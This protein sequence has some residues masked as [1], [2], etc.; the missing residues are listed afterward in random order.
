M[1]QMAMKKA[2]QANDDL[3]ATAEVT[4]LAILMRNEAVKKKDELLRE[5]AGEMK[6]AEAAVSTSHFYQRQA[7]YAWMT[8]II[9]IVMMLL[10][11]ILM[12]T[13]SEVI[14]LSHSAGDILPMNNMK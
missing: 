8:T 2:N 3:L 7:T 14:H 12:A 1:G 6:K 9:V 5:K 10:G 11:L 13:I 4:K